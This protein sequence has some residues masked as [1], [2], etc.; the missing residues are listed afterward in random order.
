MQCSFAEKSYCGIP[1]FYSATLYPLKLALT[2]LP[3]GGRSVAIVRLRTEA[4]AFVYLLYIYKIRALY[5]TN[6]RSEE[7][8]GATCKCKANFRCSASTLMCDI[9]IALE[10]MRVR[11][12]VFVLFSWPVSYT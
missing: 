11:H 3:C 4:T 8:V 10:H 7:N 2:S 1:Q 9:L 12:L 5:H 6:F